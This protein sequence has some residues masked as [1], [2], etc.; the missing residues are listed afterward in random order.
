MILEA[1]KY[2]EMHTEYLYMKPDN[3]LKGI[4]QIFTPKDDL[5]PLARYEIS[6]QRN[7]KG[8]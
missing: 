4:S 2:V 5:K 8:H 7:A 3:T 6:Q 1:W